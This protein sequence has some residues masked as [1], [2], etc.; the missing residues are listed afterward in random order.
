[1]AQCRDPQKRR[2]KDKDGE[3]PKHSLSIK[4]LDTRNSI[5]T[6]EVV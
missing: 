1:M 6:K 2:N 3:I 5:S 4:V